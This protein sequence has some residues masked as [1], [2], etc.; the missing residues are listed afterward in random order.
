MAVIGSISLNFM[1]SVDGGVNAETLPLVVNAGSDV[2]V[3]GSAFFNG[4]LKNL[5]KKH[6]KKEK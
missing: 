3:S 1:I 6:S 4:Q 2:V 5:Y